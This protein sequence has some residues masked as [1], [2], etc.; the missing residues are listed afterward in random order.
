MALKIAR[1]MFVLSCLVMGLIWTTYLLDLQFAESQIS[2]GDEIFPYSDSTRSMYLLFG[3]GLGSGI[4]VIILLSLRFITQEIFE[5]LFPALIAIIL[6]LVSGYFIAKYTMWY[7][8]PE[9]HD[10]GS[11]QL[12][13]TCTLVLLFGFIGISLGLTRASNWE[14]MMS[15][16]NQRQLTTYGNPKL[17]DTSALIDGRLNE[18]VEAGFLEG[19]LIV[20]RFV[21]HELQ[22]IADSSDVLRRSKGRRGLDV[23]KEIQEMTD[24]ISVVIVD[25]DPNP[26]DEVDSKIVALAQQFKAKV[27]TT[28]YNLNKVAQ[29]E[30]LDVLNINDLAN[31]LKPA[32]LPDEHMEVKIVKEGKE[33]FQGVGYLEDGTMIVVD[34]GRGSIGKTVDVLVTSVLQTAAGRMIFTKIAETDQAETA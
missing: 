29:I 12:Y 1:G 5:R 3:A 25:D 10:G 8:P 23:L 26:S 16:V 32:A 20:P 4:A 27:I 9:L 33:A 15:A 31:A 24:S 14:S 7:I 22:H 6:A 30:G 17:V 18:V 13:L 11:L 21:L 19:T 28:D 34:G 2:E